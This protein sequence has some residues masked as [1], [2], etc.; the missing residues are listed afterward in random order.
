M[1][2]EPGANTPETVCAAEINADGSVNVFA[3]PTAAVAGSS[4]DIDDSLVPFPSASRATTPC[5]VT[6]CPAVAT[7]SLALKVIVTD[8]PGASTPFHDTLPPSS[9]AGFT[10]PA[11]P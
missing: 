6:I 5:A 10:K 9:S 7:A 1:T 3:S 2:G 4:V 11:V 8:A